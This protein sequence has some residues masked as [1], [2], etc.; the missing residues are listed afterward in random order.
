MIAKPVA[1]IENTL[2]QQAVQIC[3]WTVW[4]NEKY[5][6]TIVLR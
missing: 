1:K 6:E 5:G 4:S 3:G 2:Q